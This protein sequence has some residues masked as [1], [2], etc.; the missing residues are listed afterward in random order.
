ML[1]LAHAGLLPMPCSVTWLHLNGYEAL[2]R[3]TAETPECWISTQGKRVGVFKTNHW[4]NNDRWASFRVEAHKAVLSMG[5][6]SRTAARL[7]GAMGE[8]VD[9]IAEHSQ[10]APTGLVAFTPAKDRLNLQSQIRESECWL[11][12]EPTGNMRTFAT[13]ETHCSAP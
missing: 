13:T 1:Q 6:A 12:Y 9:N 10:A 3:A 11:V 5:F 7:M 4:G 8:I 2:L